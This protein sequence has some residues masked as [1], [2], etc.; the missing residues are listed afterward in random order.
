MK[1]FLVFMLFLL[2]NAANDDFLKTLNEVSDIA[3]KTKV[4]VDKIPSNVEVI[5]RDFILKSGA[6]TLLDVLKYLPGVEI[7]LSSSGKRELIIRGNKSIYR[8]KIKFLIN[9]VDVTNN[10]YTNQFYYYNFPASLIKRIEFTKTP[11]SVL[12]GGTAFLGVIN[13]ITLDK[14]NNNFV[15]FY[16]SNKDEYEGGAF[17]N[18]NKF[19]I[20]FYYSYSKPDITA[21]QTYLVD[22]V[23]KNKNLYRHKTKAN[24]LEKN[25]GFG[26]RYNINDETSLSY[27]LQY[28]QKGNFFGIAKLTPL[29][30]DKRVDLIHQYIN[31][32]YKKYLKYNLKNEINTGIKH[33][34]WKGEFRNY[35]Y[36]FNETIDNDP[37][38]D[39]I[40]GADVKEYELYLKNILTYTTEKHTLTALAEMKYAKPYDM[41]YLQYVKSM[42][43]NQNAFNLGPNRKHLT[44]KYAPLKEG[45]S[46]KLLSVGFQ[47]MYIMSDDFSLI[48]GARVDKYNNF[49]PKYLYKLGGVYSFSNNSIFKLLYNK[50]YRIPSFIELY[51]QS[52]TDFNGNENLKP[53]TVD[54]VEGIFIKK[55]NE[56]NKFKF[57]YYYGKNR[58]YIGRAYSHNSGK[59]VYENLGEYI[60]KGIEISFD[61][62]YKNN[63]FYISYSYN[64]N[65]NNFKN[66][67]GG[68]NRYDWPGTREK[69]IKSY[70]MHHFS[71]DKTVF[72]SLLYGSKIKTPSYMDDINPYFSLNANYRFKV[73]KYYIN[74]GIDNLT[75][76]KNYY[77]S[78]PS[79]IIFHRYIFVQEDAKIPQAG[80]KVYLNI[81]KNWK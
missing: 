60:I 8:D 5:R 34:E 3:T 14:Y 75:D 10:L 6:K 20:D 43:N 29:K 57:V 56:N 79:N 11:D 37:A 45:I 44:G 64:K 9:G 65:K 74:L 21:P 24:T 53:E 77:F 70:I 38:N 32:N 35:P 54:M 26:L 13:I 33:Y 73:K 4:N 49:K 17:L 62:V 25:A 72:V 19:L 12:Y 23:K 41:Y 59:K 46:R 7:P 66:K 63:R 47:D 51:A 15:N 80:R 30:D 61:S 16:V 78:D 27:R 40:A 39:I 18:M 52:A 22:I 67:S 48:Y 69:M 36:D 81:E 1:K 76:H 71:A 58:D 28:Y 55:L 2:L 42:G 31:L 68:I 50:A